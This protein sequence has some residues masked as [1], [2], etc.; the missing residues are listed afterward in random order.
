LNEGDVFGEKFYLSKEISSIK[1]VGKCRGEYI[2]VSFKDN[3]NTIDTP[4]YKR[5]RQNAARYPT[6]EEILDQ[7]KVYLA[8][9]LKQVEYLNDVYKMNKSKNTELN[10]I[11]SKLNKVKNA[12]LAQ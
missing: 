6:D 2:R 9:K 12:K 7:Y 4:L 10:I 8:Q 11:K 3:V 5:I 1:I